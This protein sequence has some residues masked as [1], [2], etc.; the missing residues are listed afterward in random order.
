MPHK[1][2]P[3]HERSNRSRRRS[4]PNFEIKRIGIHKTNLDKCIRRKQPRL[5]LGIGREQKAI[6]HPH[7]FKI[8][9][10]LLQRFYLQT[11]ALEAYTLS[12]AN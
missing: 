5:Y 6:Q 10:K 2:R 9:R 12:S 11:D 4:K 7:R 3:T 1:N 8:S